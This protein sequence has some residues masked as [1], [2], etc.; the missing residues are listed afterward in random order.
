M[1]PSTETL[2]LDFDHSVKLPA[3]FCHTLDLHRYEENIRYCASMERMHELESV[4]IDE[5]RR[6]RFFLLGNGDFHHLSYLLIKNMPYK[7]MHIAVFDN[8]P[9]NMFF[10]AGI[11][12][13]S[14]VYHASKL[15]HV[16]EIS[17]FGIASGDVKGLNTVQNRLSAIRSGKVKYYCV[18]PVGRIL[19]LAGSPHIKEIGMDYRSILQDVEKRLLPL[20]TPI[21]LSI[22]KDVLST[23]YIRTTWDQGKLS[24]DE[25]MKCV[26]MLSPR[27][28]AADITGDLSSYTYQSLLKKILRRFDGAAGNLSFTAEDLQKHQAL[29]LR[30]LSLL[31]QK[32]ETL[33]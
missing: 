24:E 3:T 1:K 30:I 7:N 31:T 13:G 33:I 5:I 9:D 19:K 27:V 20:N 28:V 32:K 11:H 23:D 2:V 29:N 22:D 21:Y 17:V 10:P 26:E 18:S 25:L 4:I 16:A 8:H 6:H 15:G 14:W 12:C